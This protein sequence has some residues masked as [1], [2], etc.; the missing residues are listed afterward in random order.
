MGIGTDVR[1][2]EVEAVVELFSTSKTIWSK[3]ALCSS[4]GRQQP[5]RPLCIRF[6]STTIDE[7][8]ASRSTSA[9]C[10]DIGACVALK[11]EEHQ[12]VRQGSTCKC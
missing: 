6:S 2:E 9:V 11:V 12:L 10:A 1:D 8:K 4:A 7:Y 3:T 5:R